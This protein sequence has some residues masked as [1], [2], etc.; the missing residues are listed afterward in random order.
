MPKIF[1]N[2]IQCGNEFYI[3]EKD[4]GFFTTNNLEFPKRC[5][6]CRQR[7]KLEKEKS[8][9]NSESFSKPKQSPRTPSVAPHWPE[10]KPDSHAKKQYKRKKDKEESW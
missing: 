2:C 9:E 7:N 8:K 10:P 4:Q 5:W 3:S 1:K 6:A